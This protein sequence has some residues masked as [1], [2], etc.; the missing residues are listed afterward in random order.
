MTSVLHCTDLAFI[1]FLEKCLAW[2]PAKRL[3]PSEALNHPFIT[4]SRFASTATRLSH[5]YSDS[6]IQSSSATRRLVGQISYG[7]LKTKLPSVS[8]LTKLGSSI[9][10]A[11]GIPKS[12]SLP[13]IS[14]G[15]SS[16]IVSAKLKQ[17]KVIIYLNL[18]IIVDAMAVRGN[19]LLLQQK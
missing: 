1:D 11:V 4:N 2:D 13:P 8:S 17:N 16:R 19:F 12:Q 14:Q 3:K 18:K 7:Q 9:T 15:S 10:K 6:T 5:H